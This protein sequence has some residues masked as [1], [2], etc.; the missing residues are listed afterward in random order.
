MAKKQI[1]A[2]TE[3]NI[4]VLE[5]REA[6]RT[7][8]AMY[9]SNTDDIGLHHLVN[10]VMDNSVDEAMG[11][12]C[13]RIEV[14][15]HFDNSITIQDNGRG[16]P[17]KEHPQ[18]KGKSTLEVVHTILHAGGKFNRDAYEYS[19]GLHGVGVS[20][21]NFLSDWMEV[22]VMREGTAWRMRFESGIVVGGLEKIGPAKKTGT[23]TRF[24]P[25]PEIFSTTDFNYDTLAT[26][27][28]VLAFLNA[29]LHTSIRD[30][31]TDKSASF[32]FRGGITEFIKVLN[33]GKQAVTPQPIYFKRER[34]YQDAKSGQAQKVHFEVALQ[35]NSS[36]SEN[37]MPCAN[38]I[39]NRDGGTHLSGFR[40]ALTRTFN[41]YAKKN[42]L[43]KK[44]KGADSL[45]GD[46]VREGL[47]AI[48][49]LRVPEPQ[50]EGQNKRRLL[51]TEIEGLAQ[52]VI[53]EALME[54]LEENPSSAKKIIEKVISAAQ[55]RI[56]ARKAR[57]IVRKSSMEGGAL[58]GKLADC[59]DRDPANCELYVVEGDSA[60]GSAKQGRDRHFQAILPLRGKI[61]NVEK[62]RLDRVLAN[63][64]IRAMI[65]ALGTGIGTEN[66]DISKLRYDKLIIMT[67][68]D[69]DGAHI[70]TLLLTFFYR[71]M[72]ELI[73][74]GHVYI[75]QPPLYKV[76]KGRQ[77]QYL[78]KEADLDSYLLSMGIDNIEFE[79]LNGGGSA[80]PKQ[81]KREQLKDFTDK[82]LE[83]Y[84]LEKVLIR[85][86]MDLQSYLDLRSNE[87]DSLGRLPRYQIRHPKSGEFIYCY[88]EEEYTK[89]IAEL[90]E[91][92]LELHAEENGKD[93]KSGEQL[94]L[95]DEVAQDG[96]EE[97]PQHD[98]VEF[99]EARQIRKIIE[100]LE[101]MG[102]DFRYFVTSPLN[103]SGHPDTEYTIRSTRNGDVKAFTVEEAVD[104]VRKVGS[105]GVNIQR[106]KGLGEM[107]AEQL[108]ETTMNP[109]TRNLL[110]VTL[111]DAVAAED[112][113]TTL[114]G[115]DVLQRRSFIQRHAPEVRNLD[116]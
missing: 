16:I 36:F 97:K 9:I 34:S 112:M 89:K 22:E 43:L 41:T 70:R 77:E 82:I 2:Y 48:L 40:S 111:E 72:R 8:P 17:V 102:F 91:I 81:L 108:W 85:K 74:D 4:Q 66:F 83:L 61:I 95:V 99:P 63:T 113:F 103:E 32:C 58:P 100:S 35:Y 51:N 7:R 88:R 31:R 87:K 21:V 76:K 38:N 12:N 105:Q 104:A 6:V 96:E 93:D 52:S 39:F 23:K 24:H 53:A 109:A 26:R 30:E 37:V 67:D 69:V 75:A 84:Q 114:M 90:D 62:A 80:K 71:Q 5:G 1:A 110:Q 45:S 107:N 86:G 116:F 11:G 54:H 3:A 15:I 68:A 65:T 14:V 115:D 78:S 106:Y 33:Q 55:A 73:E 47:T 19:G 20:V 25:D 64:E 29:G 57:D 10:E 50:F 18:Q 94:D 42:D 49:S 56:A 79:I 27:C 92:W 59:S 46:D 101:R 44:L 13:D 28:R 98:V 60:G